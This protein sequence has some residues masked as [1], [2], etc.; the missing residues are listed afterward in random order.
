MTVLGCIET[1]AA[2]DGQPKTVGA[3]PTSESIPIRQEGTV[4][5]KP[6]PTMNDS[7]YQLRSTNAVLVPRTVDVVPR[8]PQLAARHN[9]LRRD[10]NWTLGS[11]SLFT[12]YCSSIQPS[13]SQ[14]AQPPIFLFFS[15]MKFGKSSQRAAFDETT[16]T[17]VPEKPVDIVPTMVV[18]KDEQRSPA[19]VEGDGQRPYVLTRAN[20]I[21]VAADSTSTLAL[22]SPGLWSFHQQSDSSA[23]ETGRTDSGHGDQ[24]KVKKNDYSEPDGRD[25]AIVP[26]NCDGN[27]ITDNEL[28]RILVE[29]IR[30][31]PES[32][33][34]YTVDPSS[35]HTDRSG[36]ISNRSMYSGLA[37]ID[38]CLPFNSSI[39]AS[40]PNQYG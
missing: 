24:V 1:R 4:S 28:H 5:N 3:G 7:P 17:V 15:P 19:F 36:N 20:P 27:Y 37:S 18:T 39:P 25:E 6:D 23:Q 2:R 8:V 32:Q 33:L 40:S 26:L 16:E 34:I 9:Q 14:S 38:L 12:A 35:P 11:A 10:Q 22:P 30:R 29:P 31:T 21:P 13:A